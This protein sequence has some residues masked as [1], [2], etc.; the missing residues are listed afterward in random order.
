[1]DVLL[2]LYILSII[3]SIISAIL[4]LFAIQF[5][6]RT[7][8]RLKLNFKQMQ[9]F[10]Q[11]QNEKTEDVL[12]S[13]D[14]EADAIKSTVHETRQELLESIE[15]VHKIRDEILESV[16]RLEESCINDKDKK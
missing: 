9:K 5:S 2:P 3:S 1:M 14:E 6:K 4:A 10:M 13:L 15:N 16:E 7:E 8:K 12:A 11:V